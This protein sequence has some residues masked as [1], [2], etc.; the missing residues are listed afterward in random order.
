MFQNDKLYKMGDP[1]LE[2][3]AKPSTLN[4]WR[5][6]RKGPPFVRLGAR[7]AYR[8]QD[9]NRWIQEKTVQTCG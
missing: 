5:V 4:H 2:R 6:E 8:G 3:I 9:L 7:I 1:E